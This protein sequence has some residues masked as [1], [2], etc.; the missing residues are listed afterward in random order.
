LHLLGRGLQDG[1][2][3]LGQAE[4]RGLLGR[5]WILLVGKGQL[6]IWLRVGALRYLHL[7]KIRLQLRLL[8]EEEPLLL[9][10]VFL[11]LLLQTPRWF[12][13]IKLTSVLGL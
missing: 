7:I 2:Q 12:F 6:L 5:W 13:T 3:G 1:A 9:E 8:L 11:Q 10:P 4:W